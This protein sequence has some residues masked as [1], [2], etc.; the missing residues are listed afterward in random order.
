MDCIYGLPF[1]GSV[2]YIGIKGGEGE[3]M[4]KSAGDGVANLTRH[5][6][7]NLT[8]EV[9]SAGFLDGDFASILINGV[10]YSPNKK[11]VN[12]VVIN[13]VSLDAYLGVF[14]THSHFNNESLLLARFI[15]SIP[16][17]HIILLSVRFDAARRLHPNARIALYSAGLDLPESDDDKRLAEVL[18]D[19]E[20]SM[21]GD[22]LTMAAAINASKCARLLLEQGWDVNHVKGYGSRNAS[23]HDAVFHGSIDVIEVLTEFEA[24][25]TIRNKWNETATDIATSL[26]GYDSLEGMITEHR[27]IYGRMHDVKAKDDSGLEAMVLE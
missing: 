27:N 2:A 7:E 15:H 1:G 16:E 20:A 22:L 12:V 14:D 24:D 8:F 6:H 25:L 5:V 9:S 23:I 13:P 21:S 17:G 19:I 10:D 3:T 18:D 26:F 4:F 11:G